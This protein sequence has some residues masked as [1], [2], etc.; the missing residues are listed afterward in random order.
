MQFLKRLLKPVELLITAVIIVTLFGFVNWLN[1]SWQLKF[2]QVNFVP[3]ALTTAIA[4]LLLCVYTL[5]AASRQR[6]NRFKPL[7]GA[8]SVIITAFSI[9]IIGISVFHLGSPK[10]D[11]F[12]SGYQKLNGLQIGVRSPIT[13]SIVLL[14]MIAIRFMAVS[15][16]GIK[17]WY[18][19][20]MLV[21]LFNLVFCLSIM[22]GYSGGIPLFYS[23]EILPV[24]LFTAIA[25][26]LLNLAILG[27]FGTRGWMMGIFDN[28]QAG[29]DERV[30]KLRN[31]TVYTFLILTAIITIGGHVV[32]NQAHKDVKARTS[33]EL[34]TIAKLINEQITQWY[35]D[36]IADAEAI[37]GNEIIRA[38][39]LGVISSNGGQK[40]AQEL[41]LWMNNRLDKY[42][43][44]RISLYNT[45]GISILSSPV[46]EIIPEA[47][48]DSLY[49][50]AL[51]QKQILITD[52][53]VE[54]RNYRELSTFT[55][56][57]IWIPVSDQSG[58]VKGT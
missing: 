1:D 24:A 47:S 56:L 12:I 48:L 34:R 11:Q 44:A 7:F 8:L 6:S 38:K 53:H 36:P 50:V 25:L 14:T 55:H 17:N 15:K 10:I 30:E 33:Q 37:L 58:M 46:K 40:S 4:I 42:N 21:A 57:N 51:H 19:K 45:K 41:L 23:G 35:N 13:A 27:L 3:M 20:G 9:Y 18:R 32:V 31:T 22:L 29:S 49:Y 39:T 54:I 16:N 5:L 52:L 28:P 2:L 43:Y 26:M